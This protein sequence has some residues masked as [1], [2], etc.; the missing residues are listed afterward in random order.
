MPVFYGKQKILETQS[1]DFYD[2]IE[3][4]PLCVKVFDTKGNLLF[5]NKGGR[6]EHFLKDTDDVSGWDWLGTVKKEYQAEVKKIFDSVLKGGYGEIEFEHIPE[7]SRHKWCHGIISPLRDKS[8]NIKLILFYSNDITVRKAAEI[9]AKEGEKMFRILLDSVSLCIKWFDKYGNF[10]SINKYGREEHFLN[11]KT[12]EEIKKWNYS[13]C[14]EKE[15]HEKIKDAMRMV[16][17]GGKKS[18]FEIR[19]IPGASRGEWCMSSFEP[20]KDENG[21]VEY[22]LFIS[23]DITEDKK[24]KDAMEG[25]IRKL[26]DS[27]KALV[28][29]LGDIKLEK[30][31]SELLAIELNKFQLAVESASEHIIITDSDAKILYANKGAERITGYSRGELMGDRP[32]LFGKQ[33]GKEFYEKMWRI[34]KKEKKEFSGEITN[35][36]KTGELYIVD[37]E[38]YPILDSGG[39]VKF[40]VGIERDITEAKGIER[41]KSD[42]ISLA[43][44][45]LRTPLTSIKWI[46]DLF[47]SGDLGKLEPRQ[48]EFIGDLH[49]STNRMIDLINSLLNIARI[50]SNQLEVKVEAVSVDKIYEDLR[51]ELQPLTVKRAHELKFER[52]PNLSAVETDRVVLYEILKNLLTNSIKYTPDGGKISISAFLKDNKILFAIKDNGYGI[53][54]SQQSRMFQKFFRG[55]NIVKID[56]TGTGLGMYIVK[57]LVELLSGEINFKSEENKG[58]AVYVSLPLSGLKS[59]G[60]TKKLEKKIE[61]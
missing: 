20:V 9:E 19:H 6:E 41:V 22:V 8:G 48:Q 23:R 24:N 44:H 7:G 35:K 11:D 25:H 45:Q 34:I 36:R 49:H 46:S 3:N 4:T 32:S 33:M 27:Q 14:I 2:L 59:K 57:S 15:Y 37:A 54:A 51:K 31:K 53:P 43:S 38:I 21:E 52:E 18:S 39:E 50:E 47:L 1:E 55:D 5:L 17:L 16:F 60:G 30:E 42:F 28:N 40:F 56:T 29:L 13:D 58:T 26:R 61:F 10:I 12:E